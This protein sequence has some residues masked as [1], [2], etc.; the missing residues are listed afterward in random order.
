MAHINAFYLAFFALV[1]R[2]ALPAETIIF[3]ELS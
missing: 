3:A 2:R 1:H